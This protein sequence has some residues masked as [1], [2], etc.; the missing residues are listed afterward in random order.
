MLILSCDQSSW[1]LSSGRTYRHDRATCSRIGRPGLETLVGYFLSET[2]NHDMKH[3][4]GNNRITKRQSA[5]SILVV[6]REDVSCTCCTPSVVQ[7]FFSYLVLLSTYVNKLNIGKYLLVL[8]WNNSNKN[9]ESHVSFCAFQQINTFVMWQSFYYLWRLSFKPYTLPM[10][11]NN[12]L[13]ILR[14][15]G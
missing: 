1:Q 12:T 2:Q 5:Q 10:Y 8:P 11:S 14:G 4:H 13:L 7:T 15:E 9:N 3:L 6:V